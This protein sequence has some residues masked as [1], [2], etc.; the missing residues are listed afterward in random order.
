M[1]Q[2][3]SLGMICVLERKKERKENDL[4]LVHY[5]VMFP[6]LDMM[7]HFMVTGS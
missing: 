7:M 1:V 5:Y 4:Q 2:P 3:F 6:L